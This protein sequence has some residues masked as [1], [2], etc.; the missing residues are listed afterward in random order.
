M[1]KFFKDNAPRLGAKELETALK[2][3]EIYHNPVESQQFGVSTGRSVAA[4]RRV[5]SYTLTAF[6]IGS[7]GAGFRHLHEMFHTCILGAITERRSHG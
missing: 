3:V 4:D 6:R 2:D 7:L 1:Q 5:V